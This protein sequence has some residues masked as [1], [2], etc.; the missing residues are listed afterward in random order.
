MKR[1]LIFTAILIFSSFQLSAQTRKIELKDLRCE[2]KTGPKGISTKIPRLSWKIISEDRDQ[3]QVAYQILVASSPKLLNPQ[4][5]DLWNSQKIMSDQNIH[6]EYGGKELESRQQC[7]WAVR[8]WDK[9]GKVS[10]W[11]LPA[12][13]EIGLLSPEDWEAEWIKTDLTFAE[14][15][16]PSPMF[17]KEFSISKPFKSARLYITSLG[18]YECYLNG[19][20]A[21]D[22]LFT[23]GWTSFENRLQYQVFDVTSL[24]KSGLNA[25]GLILGNGWYSAFY[26]NT[27]KEPEYKD[28]YALMQLEIIFN[29]GSKTIVKTDN[30]WKSSTFPILRSEIFYGEVYDARLEKQGWNQ[31]GFKDSDW[32]GVNITKKRKDILI[33]PVSEPVRNIQELYPVDIIFT[34]EGDTIF[35][36]GQNMVGWCRLKVQ[37]PAGTGIK[38]HH[39]EVLDKAGNFYIEN[40]RT[41]KQ[42]IIYICKGGNNPEVYE[43]RFTFQG[44]R[45]VKISGYQGEL[46]KDIL[47]GVVIHSDLERTGTFSCNDSLLNQLQHNIIWGQ[48]GNFLDVPTDCPQRNERLGWTGDAQ[49][50]AATACFNMNS[51]GF[52]TKWCQDLAADQHKDGAVPFVIPNV[53]GRGDAHGWAD[54]ATIVP[55]VIY[56]SY[57]DTRILEKQYQSMKAWVEYV[58]SQA[59]ESY[60]WK[61]KS[62]Q[63]GDW[64]AFATT[65]SDYPGATTD[66]DLTATAYFYNSTSLLI[67]AAEILGKVGD[68]QEYTALQNRIREAF[69]KEFVS[70]NGRLSSNTQTAYVVA[71]SFGLIPE[72]LEKT[73]AQR[74]ADNVNSFGHITT[75]FLGTADICHIL[76]KY[77]YLAE[78]YKLIYRKEYPS[79][80]YPVTKGATTIWERWDGIKPDGT[81]Q[82]PGMNS[83]NHYAY[84]AVGDW[85]YKVVAGI[86]PHPDIPGYKKIIIKPHPGNTMNDVKA[87]HESLYGSI[88]SEWEISENTFTLMV[89]IPPNTSAEIFIPSKGNKIKIDG[90]ESTYNNILEEP[91]LDYH[92]IKINKGSGKYIFKAEF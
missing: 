38:L 21:G 6:V 61:P 92:Y 60:L 25:V 26:P 23:P 82:N 85:L 29:D 39:A 55:W 14:D 65:R 22:E 53:L 7:W 1:I 76:V 77:G 27:G 24:I 64:L 73:V 75:G 49:V 15:E 42:E 9:N 83:F 71:L 12:N 11:S 37:C 86:N 36:M 30:S 20:K 67:K 40:L 32:A 35:D 81:F 17:R 41:A 4:R 43:P 63:F 54:A 78:A 68:I 10:G 66:K 18:L 16:H 51:A 57:G 56:R 28:L 19:K 33:G 34:P 31:P 84:G 3:V 88:K 13:F 62:T 52:F 74:L 2:Y 89:T 50:F 90:I 69:N 91:G 8:I 80:L 48:K 87:S 45:Y 72:N 46:N 59:G 79:W 58:R 47:T 70:P 5:A 44:F